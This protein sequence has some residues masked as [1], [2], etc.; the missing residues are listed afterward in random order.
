[1][2][3]M[4]AAGGIEPLADGLRPPDEDNPHGYF[5]LEAVRR[6]RRDASWVDDADGRAVKVIHALVTALPAHR[7]YRVVW[8][9]RPL[10]EVIASQRAMLARRGAG[11]DLLAPERL[12]AIFRAQLEEAHRWVAARPGFRSLAVDYHAVLDDPLAAAR[13]VDRFLGG[14]LDLAAMAG[15]VDPRL[16][17]QRTAPPAAP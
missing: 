12:A 1:M 9:Q 17:R 13:A 7:A 14:G 15:C 8:M 5:E 16:R 2:M 11:G 4:L 10:A 6:T 3:Q